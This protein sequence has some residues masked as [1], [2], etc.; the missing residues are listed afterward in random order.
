M[1]AVVASAGSSLKQVVL[2]LEAVVLFWRFVWFWSVEV[3]LMGAQSLPPKTAR[4]PL[5]T[6]A[7]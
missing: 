7:M 3:L 2:M 4:S 6:Y 5:R 1:I